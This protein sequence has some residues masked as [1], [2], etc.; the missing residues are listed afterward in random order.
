MSENIQNENGAVEQ[1]SADS[2]RVFLRRSVLTLGAG[3]VALSTLKAQTAANPD[4]SILN[5]ALTLE[6]LE[7]AFYNQGLQTLTAANFAAAAFVAPLGTGVTGSLFANLQAIREHENTH[8][9][10]LMTVIRSLG[11]TPVAP[12]TYNFPFTTADQFL[13]IA[14]SL[15]NT[16]VSAYI[17]ALPMIQSPALQTAGATIATVEARHAAYLNLITGAIPFPDAFD[18]PK[19]MQEILAIANQF[20]TACGTQPVGVMTT[21]VLNPKNLTTLNNT[22][23]LDATS[24][25][26]GNGQPLT[27]SVRQV[28]GNTVSIINGNTANPTVQ[29]PN[30]G[31]YVF[32]LTVTDS[33]GNISR[34]TTTINFAGR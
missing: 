10:T 33:A 4:V 17:G 28:S 34:D 31:A 8:V 15:E 24:S 26:S 29:I 22:V 11:G 3:A 2:R 7:A 27:Y 25:K 1:K 9:T 20:I 5:Y 14:A 12:C 6:H 21:A 30:F 32:E 16:G 19:T 13:T 18:I 23:T